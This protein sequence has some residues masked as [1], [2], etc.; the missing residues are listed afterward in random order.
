MSIE[1][2]VIPDDGKVFGAGVDKLE[3]MFKQQAQFHSR[4]NPNFRL[5]TEYGRELMLVGT[6]RAIIMEGAEL[7]DE[8]NWK[9]WKSAKKDVDWVQVRYEIADLMAFVMNA[10]IEARMGPDDFYQHYMRKAEVNVKR[11]E[12]GY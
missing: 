12:A 10:A 4:M 9:E 5:A 7:M 6:A 1:R 3:T 8:L 2:Q 11:Q